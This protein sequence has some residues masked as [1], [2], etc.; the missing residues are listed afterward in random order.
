MKVI[1]VENELQTRLV[2]L[3]GDICRNLML[4]KTC[5]KDVCKYIHD[6]SICFHHWKFKQCKYGDTCKKKHVNYTN[7]YDKNKVKKLL[8]TEKTNASDI[9]MTPDTNSANNE[10]PTE[11]SI[12]VPRGTRNVLNDARMGQSYEWN[13][14]VNERSNKKRV[15]NTE[16]FE[17]TSR[18]VD[19][20]I[21]MDTG[22]D[23]LSTQLT[24]RD[25][26][27][28]P[29]LFADYQPGE[30]YNKLLKATNC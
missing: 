20:R 16:S 2:V 11:V 26:L 12:E 22:K 15:K 10:V 4:N 18:P 9:V 5:E 7:K 6:P 8:I 25:I 27:L 21:V 28:V 13:N 30:L 14:K 17:P 29:N 3:R 24:D 1:T 19:V 23:R